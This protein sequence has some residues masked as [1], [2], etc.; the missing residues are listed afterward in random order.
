MSMPAREIKWAAG[1]FIG[2]FLLC[3]LL[4][5]AFQSQTPASPLLAKVTPSAE[6]PRTP[7]H[8]AVHV[9]NFPSPVLRVE[10]PPRWLGSELPPGPPYPGYRFD[11]IDSHAEV[12]KLPQDP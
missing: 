10:S 5:G 11:L 3:Y 2:G 4:I 6:W 7:A 12:P 8:I 1:G 9:T